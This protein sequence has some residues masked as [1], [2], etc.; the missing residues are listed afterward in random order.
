MP[1]AQTTAV[2]TMKLFPGTILL[3]KFLCFEGLINQDNTDE[4]CTII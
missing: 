3:L 4:W 2:I 1:M